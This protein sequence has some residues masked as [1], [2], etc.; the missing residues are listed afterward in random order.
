M[1]CKVDHRN[2]DTTGTLFG[3]HSEILDAKQPGFTLVELLVVIAI[4][5][6][7]IA[8]LLPA[9]QAA[10]EA[11]RTTKCK[12]NLKQMGLAGQTHLSAQKSF[13]SGGW[14]WNWV[15]DPDR[16][17]GVNQPGGWAYSV[18]AFVEE[19]AIRNMGK[20]MSTAA[21]YA[22]L[23][24]M[25]AQPAPTYVCPSRRDATVGPYGDGQIWNVDINLL[26]KGSRTDY[27]GNG[28]TDMSGCGRLRHGRDHSDASGRRCADRCQRHERRF[29]AYLGQL[30]SAS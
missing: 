10:R 18:L 13:P 6:I 20:G 11:A 23:A 5:G 26:T 12:N 9:V 17:Y 30:A 28:G 4:V 19:S 14:G 2:P 24:R 22:A 1:K 16:G 3:G 29:R 8:L 7:L 15:G 25:Q 21:K 27:A